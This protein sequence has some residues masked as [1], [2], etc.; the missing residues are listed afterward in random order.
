[1]AECRLDLLEGDFSFDSVV[2][3]ELTESASCCFQE[4]CSITLERT[5]RKEVNNLEPYK[6]GW[7]RKQNQG[8]VSDDGVG[9]M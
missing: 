3:G 4:N 6:E 2:K 8:C 1:M 5:R 7:Q 9:A